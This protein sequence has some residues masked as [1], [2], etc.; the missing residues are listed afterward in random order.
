M[1]QDPD[2]RLSKI[3]ASIYLLQEDL[4]NGCTH[5]E[6]CVALDRYNHQSWVIKGISSYKRRSDLTQAKLQFEEALRLEPESIE[7]LYNLGYLYCLPV[8]RQHC[9]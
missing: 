1:S 4:T 9:T 7:A 3:L 2:S 5:A 6:Q 8:H